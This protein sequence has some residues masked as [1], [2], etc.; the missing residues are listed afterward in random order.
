MHKIRFLVTNLEC[1]SSICLLKHSFPL[2]HNS[3]IFL[4]LYLSGNYKLLTTYVTFSC[5]SVQFIGD[6]M[7]I[8]RLFKDV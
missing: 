2:K 7:I 4:V 6:S 1:F 5:K 8:W 3:L